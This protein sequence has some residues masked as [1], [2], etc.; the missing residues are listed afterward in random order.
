MEVRCREVLL[1]AKSLT[2]CV[3]LPP[4][5]RANGGSDLTGETAAAMAAGAL[6]F[7]DTDP[8]YSAT[9]LEVLTV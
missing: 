4:L 6:A 9:L 1:Y 5:L 3:H 2:K 7:K 8:A